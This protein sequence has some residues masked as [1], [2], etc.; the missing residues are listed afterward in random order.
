[1]TRRLIEHGL[2]LGPVNAESGRDK[3]LR[4]GHIST[5]HL[6]WARRPLPMS[7]AVVFGTLIPD[8]EDEQ[9]RQ[10]LF[11]DLAAGCSFDES[12]SSLVGRLRAHVKDAWPNE[13][14]KVLD[15]FAGGGAIPLEALR[16]G[17]DVT[18]TDLNPVATLILKGVLEYPQRFGTTDA[19]GN[20]MLVQDFLSW[21]DWVADRA[22]ERIA[23]VFPSDDSG[24]RPAVYFWVRTMPCQNP[25][26]RLDIP[27]IRSQ[28]LAKGRRTAW[29]DVR[30]TRDRIELDVHTGRIRPK[31]S[32][33]TASCE[34]ALPSVP[35]AA[36]PSPPTTSAPTPRS[37]VSGTACSQSAT[38]PGGTGPTVNLAPKSSMAF[39]K[40]PLT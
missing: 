13:A 37:T 15:C 32:H 20:N 5:L 18:A 26:C 36:A 8:P 34:E 30:P 6:W 17:A 3:S 7:R 35:H 27:L 29:V 4:H 22:E 16:L 1:M 33:S 39:L 23:N 40:K 31:T 25:T 11:D 12:A 19:R 14:P 21:A 9:E 28:W 2:P 24:R 10:R 38:S